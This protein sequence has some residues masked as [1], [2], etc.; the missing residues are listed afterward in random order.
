MK[1]KKISNTE[2]KRLVLKVIDDCKKIASEY[3]RNWKPVNSK[4]ETIEGTAYLR[5]SDDSQVAVERG[6]LEQ[7]I[8]I[9]IMEAKSRSEQGKINYR[10]TE[11]YIE[12]GITGTHDRRP[13]FQRL[14]ADI[15]SGVHRFV[16]LKE[17]SRLV[18][19][20]E[21]WKR[22]IRL[23]QVH[24]CELCIRGLPFNPND[25]ASVLQFDQLAAFAEYE[26]RTT[27]K[28]VRESN[29][30]ALI[31]SGKFNGN[32]PLLGFDMIQND[33]GDGTGI[34]RVNKK[35]I[36]QVE[37]IMNMFLQYGHFGQVVK[38]CQ[39]KHINT[40]RGVP[41]NYNSLKRLLTNPRFLG[42]WYRNEK[43]K[44]KRQEKLMPYNRYIEVDL[45]HGSVIDESLWQR[46]QDK[47]KEIKN[48]KAKYE[49]RCYPLSGLLYLE[50]GSK[51][52]GS[53]HWGKTKKKV[54]YYY[55]KDNKVRIPVEVIENQA[56]I[57]TKSIFDNNA[58]FK[59]SLKAYLKDSDHLLQNLNAKETELNIKID[60]LSEEK[61]KLDKRLT[62]LLE[63]DDLDMVK[64]FKEEY[65]KK[66]LKLKE[67][68]SDLKFSLD[69][70]SKL[71][72][73][74]KMTQ[75]KSE[76]YVN[77][78][79]EALRLLKKKDL[80]SLKSIY[81]NLFEKIVVR[82]E[83]AKV[84]LNFILKSSLSALARAEDGFR[85]ML[86]L[87]RVMGLKPTTFCMASRFTIFSKCTD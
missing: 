51:F 20:S 80:L 8:H 57:V 21:I 34:Y 70:I 43:N 6:S 7:Q 42:K 64:M 59:K 63:D 75:G 56:E 45:P 44:E 68:E 35:E 52:C 48:S 50:D 14:Q 76:S 4:W 72:K 13:E 60:A 27:S 79:E 38:A 81:S 28:R 86:H 54:L 71:K 30:S 32:Y 65:K 9:A 26:S 24:D 58:L 37:W 1:R 12:P 5:L 53:G 47:I 40:K 31:T 49:K 10:I 2:M 29:H 74:F 3:V 23:C 84:E 39:E 62:F 85:T 78:A 17:L 73:K 61:V 67:E 16:I 19:D 55:N 15:N 18:R 33:Y 36:K 82:L 41:F 25:P 77:I 87:E 83:N 69:E 11:F 66:Y 22:F 46:V